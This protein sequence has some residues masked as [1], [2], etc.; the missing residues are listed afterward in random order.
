M[1]SLLL[2]FDIQRSQFMSLR[3]PPGPTRSRVKK[4]RENDGGH[5]CIIVDSGIVA[6]ANHFLCCTLAISDLAIS[7]SLLYTVLHLVYGMVSLINQ[8]QTR[9]IYELDY[10]SDVDGQARE[11]VSKLPPRILRESDLNLG[12]LYN[13]LASN[14][15][16]LAIVVDVIRLFSASTWQP[17]R[18]VYTKEVIAFARVDDESEIKVNMHPYYADFYCC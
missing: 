4:N 16:L 5:I 1:G 14:W 17:R 15:Y 2:S 12:I 18:V 13:R 11:L 8:I 3:V 6:H 10:D 7:Y 9:T